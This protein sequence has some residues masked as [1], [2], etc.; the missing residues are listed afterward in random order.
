MSKGED[1]GLHDVRDS[2]EIIPVFFRQ[3]VARPQG[4]GFPVFVE[5][6]RVRRF[7]DSKIMVPQHTLRNPLAYKFDTLVGVSTIADDIS[8]TVDFIGTELVNEL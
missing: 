4:D 5:M 7:Q 3:D 1:V 2:G 8:K 6:F